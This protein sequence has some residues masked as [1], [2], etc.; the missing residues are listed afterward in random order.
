M[1]FAFKSNTNDTRESAAITICKKLLNE[2]ANLV[3]HDPKVTACQIENDLNINPKRSLKN[4]NS[5]FDEKSGA[6][7]YTKTI[8]NLEI[9]N[10][11]YAVLILTEWEEFRKLNWKDISK[12]MVPPA[13]VFD[14]RSIINTDEVRDAGLNLWRI[15]D[16]LEK[17]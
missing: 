15:G 13:W 16:G 14:S 9:F 17:K 1:G 6:W 4:D 12:K 2:G 11:A 5:S 3:I 7:E 8:D 10:D